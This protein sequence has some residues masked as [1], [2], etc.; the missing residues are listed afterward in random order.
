MNRSDHCV[1]GNHA[2]SYT[3]KEAQGG[4]GGI[5]WYIAGGVVTLGGALGPAVAGL[6]I[7]ER[8]QKRNEQLAQQSRQP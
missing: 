4:L 1:Q 7:D 8:N 6:E 5:I 2:A 3:D